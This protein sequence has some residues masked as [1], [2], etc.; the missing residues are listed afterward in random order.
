M[1]RFKP[2]KEKRNYQRF[3]LGLSGRII[4]DGSGHGE[5]I[6][7][8]AHDVSAGGAFFR[9]TRP[10]PVGAHV[11]LV[12]TVGSKKLEELTGAQGLLK[13]AGTVARRTVKGMAICFC[14]DY[15]LVSTTAVNMRDQTYT[16]DKSVRVKSTFG[17]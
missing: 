3:D 12:L 17:S 9:T 5:V 11:N 7:V 8:V 14:E 10:M 16:F 6:D 1:I 2:V 13:V 15:E 4:V